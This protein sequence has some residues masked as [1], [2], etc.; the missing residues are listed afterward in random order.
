MDETIRCAPDGLVMRGTCG[1]E[2]GLRF[3]GA[4]FGAGDGDMRII[5]DKLVFEGAQ[6]VTLYIA[7][8]TDFETEDIEALCVERCQAA[9]N[10]G[11]DACLRDHIAEW[12]AA[13]GGVSIHLEREGMPARPLPM[14][15]VFEAFAKDDLSQLGPSITW[16]ALDD[17]L[18]LLLF[19]FGRYI[20]LG[21]SRNCL[22][23][24]NLQGIWCRDL[25]SVWDGKFTTNINLQMAY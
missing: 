19:S 5:G 22:L 1:G 9:L 3:R 11:F 16:Q 8:G 17:Y 23:P 24:A 25:L 18:V 13:F 4:L 21:S 2:K 10:K 7:A 20:L 14:N 15:R 6:E 12:S